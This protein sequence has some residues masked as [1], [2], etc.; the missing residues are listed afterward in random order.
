MID[1]KQLQFSYGRQTP[2]FDGLS[3]SITQGGI[4]G[5]LGKN[6]AGKTSLLKIMSGLLFAKHGE[7]RVMSANPRYRSAELL[8]EL[9]FLPEDLYVP[10][11]SVK[12]YSDLYA[13]FYP[14]FDQN[15]YSSCLAEF[16]V[17]QT[18]MLTKLSHGQKKKAML[19]FAIA[20][21]TKLLILDEPTN[22]LD[23]PSKAQ[24]RRMLA[25]Y[26]SDDRLILIST[27][28]VHDIENMLDTIVVLN[29]GKILLHETMH[30]I[31]DKL[32]FKRQVAEPTPGS[33]IYSER[34]PGGYLL[35]QHN[36]NGEQSDVDLEVL[37]NAILIHPA[38]VRAA[39]GSGE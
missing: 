19:A 28:Q 16:E 31:N 13:P 26:F 27:H 33:C 38:A 23:I 15:I 35:L 37:F 24:F 4:V 14:R 5:L 32:V 12:A 9:F 2:L 18:S 20:T 39:F 22:G 17:A 1:I 30:K 34:Q 6:G 10:A 25:Q 8:A 36:L 3:L 11:V 21:Q 7:C 29:D